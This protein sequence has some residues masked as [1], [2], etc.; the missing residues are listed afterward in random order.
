[1][2]TWGGRWGNRWGGRWGAIGGLPL[3]N[4]IS[5]IAHVAPLSQRTLSVS[6][7]TDEVAH[8]EEHLDR[9]VSI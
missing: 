1:M 6:V 7:T 2:S 4:L 9:T 5:V 8:V 3:L